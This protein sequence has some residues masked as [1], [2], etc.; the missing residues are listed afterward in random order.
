MLEM[1]GAVPGE[2]AFEGVV[3]DPPVA[4]TAFCGAEYESIVGAVTFPVRDRW[5][6]QDL[7]Q[8]AFARTWM[9]WSRISA[10]EKP[11]TWT[12]HVALNLGRSALRRQRVAGLARPLMGRRGADGSDDLD[13]ELL[14]A[15]ASLT[16]RQRAAIGWRYFADL[17]VAE[18]GGIMCCKEGTVKALTAQGVARLRSALGGTTEA[19]LRASSQISPSTWE[20]LAGKPPGRP[21]G[22]GARRLSWRRPWPASW[23][24]PGIPTRP[25]APEQQGGPADG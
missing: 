5:L 11:A 19:A 9:R 14:A 24:S 20:K 21:G 1:G 22:P 17:P 10:M 6:G 16:P 2:S 23:A 18:V 12:R 15:L 25:S 4:F 8:E 3:T 13:T 7:A